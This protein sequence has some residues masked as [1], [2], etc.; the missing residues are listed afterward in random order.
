LDPI[1]ISYILGA[2][3]SVTTPDGE[4]VS[5]EN[6]VEFTE[7]TVYS[8]FSS[9]KSDN[10]ARKDY[11]IGIAKAVADRM[12]Q[13]LGSPRKLLDAVGRAATE[14]HIAVWS[15]SLSE[16]QLLE[17]TPLAHIVP[18]DAAPYAQ[19]IVNNL[20]GNKMDYYLRR[21]IEYVADSCDGDTRNSTITVRLANTAGD[22]PLPDYV[23]G[24]GGIDSSRLPFEVPRGTMISSVRVIATKGSTLMS[25]TSNG[26]RT[27]AITG[28]ERGHPS[29]EVQVAIP[30]GKSGELTFRLREPTARGAARVPVQPLIDDVIPKVSVPACG[31]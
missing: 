16:Q 12:T 3:G 27:T 24:V 28:T 13:P 18:D 29:F 1:A 11:L 21:E 31:P 10:E 26:K 8:R 19:V 15:A 30:R 14:G 6:V 22:A 2:T 7:S 9:E 20:A 4:V 25:V 23:A 17:E 5:Q